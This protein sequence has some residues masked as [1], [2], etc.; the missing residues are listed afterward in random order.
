MVVPSLSRREVLRIAGSSLTLSIAGCEAI[1][2]ADPDRTE[3]SVVS[4]TTGGTPSPTGTQSRTPTP[5]TPSATPTVAL[6][7]VTTDDVAVGVEVLEHFTDEHPARI[8]IAIE[9]TSEQQYELDGNFIDPFPIFTDDE[10]DDDPTLILIPEE[11]KYIHPRPDDAN[12]VPEEPIDG[13]WAVDYDYVINPIGWRGL[14]HPGTVLTN[15]YT[16]LEYQNETCLPPDS[17]RVSDSHRLTPYV[18]GE[19]YRRGEITTME[20]AFGLDI[21]AD[22]SVS[23][24]AEEPSIQQSS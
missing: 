6:S 12:L 3:P 4:P 21:E 9:N 2:D 10:S 18:S 14:T 20:F 15:S 8:E 24:E 17:Y 16:V 23:A 5:D 1:D 19:E 22:G 13:C 11:T 7:P